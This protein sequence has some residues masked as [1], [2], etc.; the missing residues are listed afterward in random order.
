MTQSDG[1]A[2]DRLLR[3]DRLIV[4]V[5]LAL[6][7]LLAWLYVLAGAGMGMSAAD[8]TTLSLFPHK[9]TAADMA[10]MN[11][12]DMQGMDMSA[13]SRHAAGWT[14][15]RW[16]LTLAMWWVMMAAMM[17][18]SAAPA[19]LLYGR[20]HRTAAAQQRGAAI[21]PAWAFTLGYLLVWLAFSLAATGLHF[22]LERA[23][24]VSPGM[25]GSQ[26]RWLSAGVLAAAG[27]YQLSPL[28]RVCLDHCRG[29]A[30]FFTR[31]WRPGL[32]GAVRLG[33]LH[34]AYCVGCCWLLMALLFVG[35][36]MNLAWIAA[37]ALLVL[38]E[39]LLPGGR[40]VGRI[41]GLLLIAWALATVFV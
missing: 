31:H 33:V 14:L 26:N 10:G 18:P 35:G 28:H 37:I 22:G 16:S 34:G 1:T 25:M 2:L 4:G 3:R 11:A 20:V 7:A 36:V 5:S 41:A 39:K 40:W 29:P 8:M 38:G 21:G 32:G 24:L 13:A 19:I 12:M 6:L 23:G 17:T 27:V 9:T 30:E 15:D